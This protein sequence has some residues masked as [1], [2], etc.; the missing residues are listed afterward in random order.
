MTIL[1]EEFICAGSGE[2]SHLPIKFLSDAQKC[3]FVHEDEIR[4][5]IPDMSMKEY[6]MRTVSP[7]SLMDRNE[8]WGEVATKC[9]VISTQMR[10]QPFFDFGAEVSLGGISTAEAGRWKLC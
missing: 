9:F 1:R 6:G 4:G 5:L 2:L 8:Y 7:A 3:H 10:H